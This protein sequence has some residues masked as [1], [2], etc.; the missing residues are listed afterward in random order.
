MELLCIWLGLE[1]VDFICKKITE[2]NIAKSSDGKYTIVQPNVP[3]AIAAIVV[4]EIV[5][6]YLP[7]IV[8]LIV[9]VF[10]AGAFIGSRFKNGKTNKKKN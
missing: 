8:V 9:T 10:A 2:R 1:S 6:V 5:S 7:D 4:L 3:M